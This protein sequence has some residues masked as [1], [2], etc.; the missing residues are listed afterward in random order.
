MNDVGRWLT[1]GAEVT[2]GLRLLDRLAPNRYLSEMVRRAPERFRERLVRALSPFSDIPLASAGKADSGTNAKPSK[3]REQWPFLKDPSCPM[4]LKVLAADKITAY[5]AMTSLHEKLYSCTSTE[6]SFETAKKL[7]EN[8]RQNS[9]IS[10]EFA[11]YKENGRLLG[12]HP[13]FEH[14]QQLAKYQKMDIVTLVAEQR[15]LQK[16]IW[17]IES[18]LRAKDRPDL[19]AS[20][21]Q[22]LQLKKE[23]LLTVNNLI[24]SYKIKK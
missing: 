9:L 4:E 3:F 8:Y 21:E 13:I 19:S 22:R 11:Y 2:E 10:A 24:E 16:C 6:E 23:K 14:R 1:S 17:R 12:K 20:R 5:E 15:K 18:E 7:L